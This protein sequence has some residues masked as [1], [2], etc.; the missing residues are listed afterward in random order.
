MKVKVT[1]VLLSSLV[2]SFIELSCYLALT[3]D[4]FVAS[5]RIILLIVCVICFRLGMRERFVANPYFCFLFTPF[6]L[7]I[8]EPSVSER[9]LTALSEKTYLLGVLSCLAFVAGVSQKRV[10]KNNSSQAA[11]KSELNYASN[12][13]SIGTFLVVLWYIYQISRIVFHISIPFSAI[14]VQSVYIGIAFLIMSKRPFA[15][16]LAIV[17]MIAILITGFRKTSFLYVFMLALLSV[18]MNAKKNSKTML[19][20]TIVVLVGGYVLIVYAYPLKSYFREFGSFA[21]L[22]G[23]GELME[24]TERNNQGY[25]S[26]SIGGNLDFILLRP[27]L[28]MT[29]SWVNLDYVMQ[30][31][32]QLNF[33]MWFLKP[34]LN[35]LQINTDKMSVYSL[36]PRSNY[37]NTFGFLTVQLKDFGFFGAII[38]TYLEGLF[39]SWVYNRFMNHQYSPLRV[40]QYVFVSCAVLEMFFSNHFLLGGIHIVFLVSWAIMLVLKNTNRRIYDLLKD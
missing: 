17:T 20:G 16:T 39:A 19:W 37:Y 4:V 7:M 6:S 36:Y 21:G 9:F 18:L 25:G 11:T 3:G 34:I 15:R 31:Q 2:L 12:F 24:I 23:V 27:Y 38:F 13:A 8:F 30:T 14:L 28:S 35:I 26:L 22:S 29:S 5:Q 33:G 10:E 32:G 40:A 1:P